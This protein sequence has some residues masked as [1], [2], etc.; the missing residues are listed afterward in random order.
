[1]N[2]VEFQFEPM[3]QWPRKSTSL[4]KSGAKFQTQYQ[5][6]L[7][8]IRHELGKL[9]A[10]NVVIQIGLERRDIRQDGLPR[11]DARK[12]HHPGIILSFGSNKGDLRFLC[13]NYTDW[14]ANL[15]A[16]AKLLERLRLLDLDG[17]SQDDEPYR[18]WQALPPAPSV[19]TVTPEASAVTLAEWSGL[20]PNE[21]MQ[22]RGE[23]AAG[24]SPRRTSHSPGSRRKCRHV[25]DYSG[26]V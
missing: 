18:G 1:M 11:S 16:I 13:D 21:I 7:I 17:V 9:N 10:R 22:N 15:R 20:T 19:N 5:Q 14:K 8:D 4:R 26:S 23:S 3:E 24:I 2:R 6:T 25:S 12:P